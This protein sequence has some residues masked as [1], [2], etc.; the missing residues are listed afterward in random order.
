[1]NNKGQTLVLLLVFMAIMII[2]VSAVTAVTINNA[3]GAGKFSQGNLALA[4]AES[5]AENGIL[6]VL[7]DPDYVGEILPVGNG[8]AKIT[9]F[10]GTTPVIQ[11]VATVGNFRRVVE[12]RG[13]FN[14]NVLTITSWKEL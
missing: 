14:N 5:G 6:R 11:S 1:M 2:V 3:V 7:R 8:S 10:G 9:I 12:V 13:S 4:I